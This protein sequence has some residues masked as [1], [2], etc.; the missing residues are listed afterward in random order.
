[1]DRELEMTIGPA[2]QTPVESQKSTASQPDAGSEHASHMLTEQALSI[3]EVDGKPRSKWRLIAIVIALF[4][5]NLGPK[6]PSLP[7]IHH[8]TYPSI[9]SS[10]CS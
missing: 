1:M 6:S 5:R 8:H 2:I 10:H 7:T 3:S 9:S 4:V